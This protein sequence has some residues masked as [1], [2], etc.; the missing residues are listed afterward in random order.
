MDNIGQIKAILLECQL[1]TIADFDKV[2]ISFDSEN[3]Y[4]SGVKLKNG[5]FADAEKR[6]ERKLVWRNF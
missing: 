4:I 6:V 2:N 3:V 5:E 1:I